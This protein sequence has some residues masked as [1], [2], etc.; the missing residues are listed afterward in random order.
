[1]NTVYSKD[2]TVIA[3]DVYGEGP[4][5]IYI[6]G[7]S[8]HRTF[9]PIV[10]DVRILS[11]VFKVY[12]YDRRG[13]G[14]SG[15]NETYTIKKEIE[16]IESIIDISGE[17]TFL[18][19]HS[20]GAVLALEAALHLGQKVKKIAIYDAPYVSDLNEQLEYMKLEIQIRN[21]ISKKMYS[22]AIKVFL[23]KIGMPRLFTLMLPLFPGWKE[24]K[25]LAPTLLY[26]IELTKVFPPLE[27]LSRIEI[28]TLILTGQ[29]SPNT[30]KVV[31]DQMS[32]VIRNCSFEIVKDQNHLV[33]T[34]VIMPFLINHFNDVK[35][36]N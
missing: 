34:K 19:G 33:D 20:S 12:S 29:K 16:D 1:L 7:A 11:R 27:K 32:Q 22:K 3:Y 28:P 36:I 10:E 15:N 30:I 31:A 17:P 23:A 8:C 5:L 18:F 6:T 35:S 24:I 26:D 2:S 13:R 25:A 9:E 14:N 4:S 21:L